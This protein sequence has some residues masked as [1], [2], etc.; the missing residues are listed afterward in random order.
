MFTLTIDQLIDGNINM[1]ERIRPTHCS[2]TKM[3]KRTGIVAMGALNRFQQVVY[4]Q[5]EQIKLIDPALKDEPKTLI[6]SLMTKLNGVKRCYNGDIL[7]W[8]KT[9]NVKK[10]TP[11]RLHSLFSVKLPSGDWIDNN[12]RSL[13]YDEEGDLVLGDTYGNLYFYEKRKNFING[14]KEVKRVR[15]HESSINDVLFFKVGKSHRFVASCSRD[16]T[17]QIF[18]KRSSAGDELCDWELFQT[19]S[20]HKGN[21]LK[22]AFRNNKLIASSADRTLSVHRFEPGGEFDDPLIFQEKVISNKSSSASFDVTDKEI[23]VSTNDKNILIY[24][25]STYELIKSFKLLNDDFESIQVDQLRV[26]GDFL[27]TASSDKCIRLFS[28]PDGKLLCSNWAHSESIISMIVVDDGN[29]ISASHDGCMFN[30]SIKDLSQPTKGKIPGSPNSSSESLSPDNSMVKAQPKVI[31]KILQAPIMTPPRSRINSRFT[32]RRSSLTSSSSP[33]VN[34][35]SI[36]SSSGL[37]YS[38]SMRTIKSN[39]SLKPQSATGSDSSIGRS[40]SVNN[41]RR[42]KSSSSISLNS[43][44]SPSLISRYSYSGINSNRSST[45]NPSSLANR[46]SNSTSKIQPISGMARSNSLYSR[47]SSRPA[48]PI[49]QSTGYPPDSRLPS[50]SSTAP[51]STRDRANLKVTSSSNSALKVTETTSPS[52]SSFGSHV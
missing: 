43:T 19:L 44:R 3:I 29:L 22:I 49:G 20:V 27:A 35:A 51:S 41:L 9:G 42:M 47:Q 23:I 26:H 6:N 24:N 34:S 8:S 15:A 37:H 40:N 32:S 39:S 21:V 7:V 38:R 16:R 46:T 28:Y 2:P 5:D 1:N 4:L 13:D 33:L 52:S 36:S 10:L 25:L 18:V 31:R 48:S 12:L 14:F 45:A 50:N 30:W 11:D 17:I